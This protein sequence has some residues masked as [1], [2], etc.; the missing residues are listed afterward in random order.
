MEVEIHHIDVL[1]NWQTVLQLIE[2]STVVFNMI[3]V[4][5][6]FDIAV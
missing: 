1:T 3:D 4:G 2:K 6:Y 5:D